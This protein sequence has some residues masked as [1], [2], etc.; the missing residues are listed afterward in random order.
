MLNVL[1][2]I[3]AWG[4]LFLRLPRWATVI[5]DLVIVCV[6][7]T[8]VL[9]GWLGAQW[10]GTTDPGESAAAATLWTGVLLLLSRAVTLLKLVLHV[11]ASPP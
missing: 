1:L 9:M 8:F 11:L 10:D 4:S 3:A 7:L 6:G 2:V 5:V